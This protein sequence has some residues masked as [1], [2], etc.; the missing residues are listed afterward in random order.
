MA[1]GVP[2]ICTRHGTTAFA[3]HEKTALV[4]D[5]PS[6]VNLAASI[7]RL[8]NDLVLCEDLSSRGRKVIESYS[9]DAYTKDLLSIIELDNRRHYYCA[10]ELELFGKWPVAERARGLE[11]LLM[12]AKGASVVDFGAAEGAISRMFL[13]RGAN[14]LHG[15][16]L[17]ARRI[18]A[19]K[20]LCADWNEQDF[21]QADLSD[22]RQFTNNHA[23]LLRKDYDIVLYLGIHHHLP[24]PSRLTTLKEAIRLAKRFFAFR[25]PAAVYESDGVE[26]LLRDEG[27]IRVSRD[28]SQDSAGLLGPCSIYE[29]ASAPYRR[30]S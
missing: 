15:F 3:Y 1:S 5:H 23:E 11:L 20:A 10:P 29:R 27:F 17:D 13:D 14:L 24:L 6:S 2:V 16:E 21:R 30:T 19:A 22:W 28:L 9:W 18:L 25:A 26:N 8:Q 7:R 4:I 12:H